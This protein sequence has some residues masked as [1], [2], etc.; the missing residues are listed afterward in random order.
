M[1]VQIHQP[2]TILVPC[3]DSTL[4]SRYDHLIKSSD[5]A[6]IVLGSFNFH[7]CSVVVKSNDNLVRLENKL[8]TQV[9]IKDSLFNNKNNGVYVLPNTND[10]IEVLVTWKDVLN[11]KE[12]GLEVWIKK[13]YIHDLYV[14]SYGWK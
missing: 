1:K 2:C 10:D 7:V 14:L 3:N 6:Q 9:D 11:G 8:F 12:T 5:D 4:C 13:Q